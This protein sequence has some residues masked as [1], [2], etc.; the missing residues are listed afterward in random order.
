MFFFIC[1]SEKLISFVLPSPNVNRA[2]KYKEYN[3]DSMKRII[4]IA[5]KLPIL[6][7]I[8][9][10]CMVIFL[11]TFGIPLI[12]N[13]LL[14]V[15][16]EVSFIVFYL[17]LYTKLISFNRPKTWP[18]WVRDGRRADLPPRHRQLGGSPRRSWVDRERGQQWSVAQVCRW[19]S[20]LWAGN[21]SCRPRSSRGTIGCCCPRTGTL[22][23]HGTPWVQMGSGRSRRSLR[24]PGVRCPRGFGNWRINTKEERF[25]VSDGEFE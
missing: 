13:E 9:S 21:R 22:H 6:L 20:R 25:M 7:Q 15:F 24:S 5:Y 18:S 11:T 4:S 16:I 12:K 19:P 3:R 14:M 10:K 17:Y 2:T 8:K 1:I 23:G